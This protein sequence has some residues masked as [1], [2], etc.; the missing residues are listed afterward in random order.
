MTK[1]VVCFDV[2]TTGL[3][4]QTNHIIQLAMV[5]FDS[6]TWQIVDERS[7]YIKPLLDFTIEEFALEKHGLT[8]EFI[9]ENGVSLSSIYPDIIKM[10][11]DCDVLTYNGNSFDVN[12]LYQDLK[13]YGLSIDYDRKFY[14]AYTIECLRSSRKLTDV[15]KK[16]TGKELE[17]AHNAFADTKATI[18]VFKYQLMNG[19]E[20]LDNPS[21]DCISPDKFLMRIE[22]GTVVFSSGKYSRKG[23]ADVCKMNPS[24]I[25]WV[26][27]NCSNK[28]KETIKNEYYK[29]KQQ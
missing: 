29:S 13:E 16:Y 11:G 7:W 1:E 8:K 21:F 17:D 10:L 20:E 2:E 19:R 25:R 6:E 22:D 27:E 14:D 4:P 18:E 3:N 9:L 24:Y 5:K 12:F 26:F 28:T 15:Y 23:V